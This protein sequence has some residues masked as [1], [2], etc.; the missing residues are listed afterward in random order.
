MEIQICEEELE[1]VLRNAGLI[2]DGDIVTGITAIQ[3]VKPGIRIR[4]RR[5]EKE[6]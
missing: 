4:T 3:G 5:T 6:E 2:R 1:E